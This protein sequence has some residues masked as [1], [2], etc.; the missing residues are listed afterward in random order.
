M[1]WL[2][3][4][5]EAVA[6]ARDIAARFR[7]AGRPDYQAAAL[8]VAARALL[9]L[10]RADEARAVLDEALALGGDSEVIEVRLRLA[11]TAARFLAREDARESQRRL[12]QVL[13]EAAKRGLKGVELEVS[14]AVAEVESQWESSSR[15]QVEKLARLQALA[16]EARR[17]GF[18]SITRRATA[19]MTRAP[20]DQG[21]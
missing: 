8:G 16:D 1:M 20:A 3:E 9:Q 10:G 17:L 11:I 2:G 12:R 15:P 6:M 21:R 14:L 18:G 13:G 4:V 7:E 5:E 19:E